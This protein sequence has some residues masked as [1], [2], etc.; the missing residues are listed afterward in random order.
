MRRSALVCVVALFAAACSAGPELVVTGTPDG[1]DEAPAQPVATPL[2]VGG[3]PGTAPKTA[4]EPDPRP[5]VDPGDAVPPVDEPPPLVPDESGEWRDHPLAFYV[6]DASE[7]GADWAITDIDVTEYGLPEPDPELAA[8][9]ITEPPTLD[10]IEVVYTVDLQYYNAVSFIV[11]QGPEAVAQ[12]FL[13]TLRALSECD[14]ETPGFYVGFVEITTET[15][16]I[17]GADDAV[18]ARYAGRSGEVDLEGTYAVV[19]YGELLFAMTTV[20]YG[21]DNEAIGLSV[22]EMLAI[23]ERAAARG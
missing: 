17:D 10:G 15:L 1:I 9:G 14:P 13:D 2:P 3:V 6:P 7:I 18:V 4:T 16:T 22:D 5:T 11:N 8:C 19:R 12:S 21:G 20:S 23:L